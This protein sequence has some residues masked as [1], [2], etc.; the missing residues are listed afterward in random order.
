MKDLEKKNPEL[1][2]LAGK[3]SFSQ[4]LNRLRLEYT[5]RY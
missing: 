4:E 3:F 2:K 5:G 1:M